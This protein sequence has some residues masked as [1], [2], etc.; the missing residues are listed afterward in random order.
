M[1]EYVA[2]VIANITIFIMGLFFGSFYTLARYRIPRKIDII[3]KPS[4]CP[5]C[6]HKLGFWSQIPVVS[7][8]AQG[9][10]C[11]FCKERIPRKYI[12]VELFTGILFLILFNSFNIYSVIA[13]IQNYLGTENLSKL[14]GVVSIPIVFSILI[15]IALID[16]DTRKINK[17]L[18]SAL[19]LVS[20]VIV[21]A[22]YV[23]VKKGSQSQL[24]LIIAYYCIL[25]LITMFNILKYRSTKEQ[26]Y[27]I[28][29]LSLTILLII[30]FNP[31]VMLP[32]IFIFILL[33]T[34]ME[35]LATVKKIEEEK[36]KNKKYNQTEEVKWETLTPVTPILIF[37]TTAMY[38]LFNI[39]TYY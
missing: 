38:V 12:K 16:K 21:F 36:V 7:Y 26:S 10:K 25:I 15:L 28:D 30:T 5:T 2:L 19:T 8:L 6:D 27:Y 22:D 23:F 37:S 17:G 3:K 9:G 18:M 35:V 13:P 14:I 1:G 34:I 4:F 24:T 32:A 11:R 33:F 39:V 31:I 20:A 29:L